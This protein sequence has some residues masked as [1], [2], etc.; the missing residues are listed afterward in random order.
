MSRARLEGY[1]TGL[2]EG[3]TAGFEEGRSQA[4]AQ[5]AQIRQAAQSF[6]REL[7]QANE[8][9]AQEILDLA[10]DFARAMLKSAL[11]IRPEIVLPVVSEAIRYLPSVE[12]PAILFLHPGDAA[13]IRQYLGDELDKAG[14]RLSE[15]PKMKRGGCRVETASNQID[16]TLAT[17]WQRLSA[18]LNSDSSWLETP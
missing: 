15:D 5:A 1:A 3:R 11:E 8:L 6:Q 13:I 14:W 12:Q 16:A 17:R 4:M 2:A 7:Q 9:V 18:S 10:L